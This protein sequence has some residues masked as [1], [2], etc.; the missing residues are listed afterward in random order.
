MSPALTRYILLWI[1]FQVINDAL[2]GNPES[3]TQMTNGYIQIGERTALEIAS[4]Q[5]RIWPQLGSEV[6]EELIQNEESIVYSQAIHYANRMV[7]MRV[8]L[9]ISKGLKN[10]I[11]IEGDSGGSSNVTGRWVPRAYWKKKCHS[12]MITSKMVCY[13]KEK[14]RNIMH[15]GRVQG[16]YWVLGAQTC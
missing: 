2:V 13:G 7:C 10:S 4:E 6:Q 1:L 8:P 3:S 11:S 15:S 16:A 14:R 5:I 9:D 12:V